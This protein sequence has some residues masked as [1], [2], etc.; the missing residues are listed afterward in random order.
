MIRDEQFG[1]SLKV[2]RAQDRVNSSRRVR[3]ESQVTTF[4]AHK[5]RQGA[6]RG[7]QHGFKVPDEKLDGLPLH[8]VAERALKI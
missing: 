4:S 2:E 7:V 6:A 1:P 3:D 5:R 8:S